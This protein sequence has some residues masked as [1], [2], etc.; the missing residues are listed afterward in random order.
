MRWV[1]LFQKR[2][3]VIDPAEFAAPLEEGMP[4]DLYFHY[5]A[6][7]RVQ[8]PWA[9]IMFPSPSSPVL[10]V[11]MTDLSKNRS[12]MQTCLTVVFFLWFRL[13]LELPFQRRCIS[14]VSHFQRKHK[15]A[16]K[17]WLTLFLNRHCSVQLENIDCTEQR[18]SY[19][20]A[21]RLHHSALS[22]FFFFS[23]PH[24]IFFCNYFCIHVF[25]MIYLL[26]TEKINLV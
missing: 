15:F 2:I 19:I 3:E 11:I 13:C 10:A 25:L 21:E 12:N 16:S 17:L 1:F 24:T 26:S 14:H 9:G 20:T 22:I 23:V 18:E 8:T 4:V 5:M 6:P 7:P